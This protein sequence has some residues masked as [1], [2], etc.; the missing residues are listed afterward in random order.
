MASMANQ[1]A[2][3]IS[4][5]AETEFSLADRIATAARRLELLVGALPKTPTGIWSEQNFNF[6]VEGGANHPPTPNFS[7]LRA[8]LRRWRQGSQL[9]PF[10]WTFPHASAGALGGWILSVC[11]DRRAELG[12]ANQEFRTHGSAGMRILEVRSP[13]VLA[14]RTV[15]AGSLGVPSMV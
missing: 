10:S 1:H 15:T 11:W 5:L 8:R 12:L 13:R 6:L 3:S 14:R 2:T 7:G 9:K 4:Y